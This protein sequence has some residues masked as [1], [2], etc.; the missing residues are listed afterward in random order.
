MKTS[1]KAALIT[2]GACV[3]LG[4][5]VSV[6][7]FAKMDYDIT[8]L[9]TFVY[10]TNE[11]V[12]ED[13]F[14]NIRIEDT[15]SDVR[16]FLSEDNK[17]TAKFIEGED[18]HHTARVEN[19][20]LYITNDE[21]THWDT[22]FMS[23]FHFR[24]LAVELYLPEKEY[25]DLYVEVSSGDV[26]VYDELFFKNAYCECSSGDISFYADAGKL[27]SKC[28]SGDIKISGTKTDTV[29]AKCTSGD[30][31]ALGVECKEFSAYATSGDIELKSVVSSGNFRAETSSGD[32]ELKACDGQKVELDATSG[33]I[34]G[35]FLT[36]KMFRADSSS[37]DV[38]L[39]DDESAINGSCNANTS[40]GDI[41]LWI[42][43]EN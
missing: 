24:D 31:T 7:A 30:I 19:G 22:F 3:L 43:N 29:E 28:T 32:I 25:N 40:S 5:A 6:S 11:A 34:E 23:V 36:N 12:I 27:T 37:G 17:C 15:N 38:D 20:T 1:K 39:P 4:A 9:D 41:E 8:R 18:I 13:K 2:A 14:Q 33:D 10:E 35:S 16:I 42:G 26:N 21:H